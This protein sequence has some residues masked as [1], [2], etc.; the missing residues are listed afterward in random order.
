MSRDGEELSQEVEVA[1]PLM[2]PRIRLNLPS[3]INGA[4]GD[5]MNLHRRTNPPMVEEL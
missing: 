4:P 1:N 2:N 5:E 3:T